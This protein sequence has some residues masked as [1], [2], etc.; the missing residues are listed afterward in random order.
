MK[1]PHSAI[2]K[3]LKD[4]GF[5]RS[6]KQSWRLDK[7]Q[8]VW[9]VKLEGANSE[10]DGIQVAIDAAAPG[11]K[12]FEPQI[13]FLLTG[14]MGEDSLYDARVDEVGVRI[15]E[16]FKTAAIPLIARYNTFRHLWEA[17]LYGE[18]ADDPSRGRPNK[19]AALSALQAAVF[20]DLGD[21]YVEDA[22][23]YMVMRG[24]K[25]DAAD[26]EAEIVDIAPESLMR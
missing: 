23:E 14:L 16:D 22:L 1:I 7:E 13:W 6:G 9:R 21:D 4:A 3:T 17:L 5:R 24:W 26:L 19:F 18:I 20:F 10:R 8:I 2:S 11:R 12:R 25:F 15:D